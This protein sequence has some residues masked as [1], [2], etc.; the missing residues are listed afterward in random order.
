M[1]TSVGLNSLLPN[2]NCVVGNR[3]EKHTFKE[4]YSDQPLSFI[5]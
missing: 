2:E 3:Q 1:K 4:K 5:N